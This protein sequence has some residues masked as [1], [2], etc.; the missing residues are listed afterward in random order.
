MEE[1]QEVVMKSKNNKSPG[2]DGICYEFYKRN[3]DIIKYDILEVLQCQLNRRRIV[4]SN[5][6]GV[7]RLCSKVSGIPA[8]DDLRPITLLNCDYK[9][10]SKCLV[11]RIRPKLHLVIK[12][13]Q[14]CSIERKNILFGVSNIVS[15][16]LNVQ[17]K[18]SQACLISLDFYKAYD[19][20]FW[21][22]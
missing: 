21:V 18:K 13:G 15:S 20:F 8:V 4:D 11:G 10:L 22:S 9:L 6:E 7:T 5:K 17:R 16:I 19:E 12:S 1:L 14:L 2:I 3:W